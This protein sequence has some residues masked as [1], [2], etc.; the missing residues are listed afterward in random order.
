VIPPV[1][2]NSLPS[3]K[4]CQVTS[5]AEFDKALSAAG[6]KLV[7]VDFFAD[8]CGPCVQI[9]PIFA[10][11]ATK[12]TNC[13]FV[14]VNVDENQETSAKY[15]VSA[16]PT[17]VYFKNGKEIERVQGGD[18]DRLKALIETHGKSDLVT[19]NSVGQKDPSGDVKV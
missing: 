4:I 6:T 14:K 8:W 5:L 15:Q 17:F 13:A 18:V 11:L 12:H 1:D 10:E 19:P 7:I 2:P 9:A 3:G 16:M